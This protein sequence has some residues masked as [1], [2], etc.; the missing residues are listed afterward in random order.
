MS[1]RKIGHVV[2]VDSFRVVIE[3]DGD[4]KSLYKS[5]YDNIYD[6]ARINSYV[7]LPVGSEKI[8]AY[9]TRVKVQDETE[10]NSSS[11][12][13]IITLPE[14]KRLI[15]ATMIGTIT[16]DKEYVQGVYNFPILDNPVWYVKTEDL[17]QIFDQEQKENISFDEDYFLPVGIPP[18][19]PDYEIKINP[20]Q[21]F[22][23]HAAVL[24]NTGSGKSCTIAS[25]LQS[26]FRW[27]SNGQQINSANI[28]IFDTN[29]EYKK[30]FDFEKSDL[31][32]RVNAL[33]ISKDGLKVPYWFMNYDDFDYL[34]QP[35]E[36][37]QAP[38]LKRALVKAKDKKSASREGLPKAI[39]AE[40]DNVLEYIE[41][42]NDNELNR[43]V[44]HSLE[45][46][47]DFLEEY[48]EELELHQ[49]LNDLVDQR[50][51][52]TPNNGWV[53]GVIRADIKQN[54]LD[55]LKPKLKQLDKETNGASVSTENDADLP[56]YFNYKDLFEECIDE[57]IEELETS[58]SRI[59]EYVTTLIL[60]IR[61]YY[62][63]DRISIPFLLKS[64][65]IDKALPTFLSFLT[66]IFTK[67]I[68]D[69]NNIYSEYLKEEDKE[70]N[71]KNV[72][73]TESD[74][75]IAIIDLSLLPYEVLE[76]VTGLIGRLI[77]EFLQ[78]LIKVSD[79]QDKRGDF[80]IVLV[81]EEAQNYIPEQ[82]R[83]EDRV[84]ISKRVFERI[85]REGRK[86]GLSLIIASQ[87]PS[88]LS[89][90]ILSQCN[91]YIIHRLQNPGDQSYVKKLVSSANED[92][93][94]QL[95]VLPQQHAVITGDAVR[96]PVQIKINDVNPQPD[97]DDP[98]FFAK[99]IQ[100]P[101][102]DLNKKFPDFE[103]VV[104]EWINKSD[105]QNDNE[106]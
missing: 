10:L 63:D 21:L 19:F 77:L 57:A 59:R 31:N 37:S 83:K 45:S 12:S 3:L 39:R 93:L 72:V 40:L 26:I 13:G 85:A 96:S 7:I 2:S 22:G 32:E 23:K 56:I 46:T 36:G 42:G 28:I 80:P 71:P 4:L 84:S 76:N 73:K 66:G 9:I 64:N 97:S 27:E 16:S 35:A 98:E 41:S 50:T 101:E 87:R 81:L 33:N 1:D 94:N 60:R 82:D 14:S 34:F 44:Y 95:P 89:R 74:S 18:A 38:V 48:Y 61:S 65:N 24:G 102:Q 62:Y 88:E 67:A 43:V 51:N 6:I 20:D 68:K 8:V 70:G 105:N 79:Y 52:L 17:D 106:E 100:E 104:N 53:N 30:A 47:C 78:R 90:T 25:I 49:I 75:Q 11:S 91:S 29:G 86:Y 69:T 103:K 92:I 99:W 54:V 5:G 55:D 58:S 15:V